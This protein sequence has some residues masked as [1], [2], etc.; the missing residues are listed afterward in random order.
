MSIQLRLKPLSNKITNT[1]SETFA[2]CQKQSKW[3]F[4]CKRESSPR[5]GLGQAFST[6]YGFPL[7]DRSRGQVSREWQ[8]ERIFQRSQSI[9]NRHHEFRPYGKTYCTKK[10]CKLCIRLATPWNLW[11]RQPDSNR[12]ITVLQTAALATWLCR[13]FSSYGAGERIWTVDVHLG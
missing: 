3:S 11:R 12:W 2:F 1:Q 4:P 8:K 7:P 10:G 6:C 9:V 5:S 13:L